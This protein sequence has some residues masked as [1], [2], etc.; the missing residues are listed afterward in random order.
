MGN[1]NMYES[2]SSL[3]ESEVEIDANSRSRTTVRGD[4]D[5]SSGES[6]VENV[7]EQRDDSDDS[8]DSDES[9]D[10]TDLNLEIARDNIPTYDT[11]IDIVPTRIAPIVDEYRAKI[12]RKT[13]IWN[14]FNRIMD[15]SRDMQQLL[16][17][18][19]SMEMDEKEREI[20]RDKITRI[21]QKKNKTVAPLLNF[22]KTI[23]DTHRKYLIREE[24]ALDKWVTWEKLP[25]DTIAIMLYTENKQEYIDFDRFYNLYNHKL[26]LIEKKKPQKKK[27]MVSNKQGKIQNDVAKKQTETKN[28]VKTNDNKILVLA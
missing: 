28:D 10:D 8:D 26:D 20:I 12:D 13:T 27:D 11:I 24:I 15:Q 7:S 16:E 25:L 22:L 6:D 21:K 2:D 4:V 3:S 17:L 9:E 19:E 14:E 18:Q 1:T 5:S 23:P